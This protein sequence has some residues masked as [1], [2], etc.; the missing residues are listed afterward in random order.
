MAHV[1]RLAKLTP[2][3]VAKFK[4]TYLK[5]GREERRD[6]SSV[7]ISCNTHLRHAAALFSKQMIKVYQTLHVEVANPFLGQNLRR[8]ELKPSPSRSNASSK[9]SCGTAP[10]GLDAGDATRGAF[11]GP[12]NIN[13]YLL[14][15][16][17]S[18]TH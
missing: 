1:K 2:E 11:E 16:S 15:R 14:Q 10:L 8:I 4:R 6:E 18:L 12:W 5:L 9:P 13:R 17:C 3:K 7:K